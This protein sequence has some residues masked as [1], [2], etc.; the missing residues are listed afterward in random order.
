MGIYIGIDI[1]PNKINEQ[2]WKV[3]FEETLQLIQAYPFATLNM[4]SVNGFKRLVLERAKKQYIEGFEEEEGYWKINGDLKSKDT[5]ES[6]TMF[7]SLN[8]YSELKEERLKEDIL[9]YYLEDGKSGAREVFY[10]KTQGKDYHTYILAIAT[11]IE[12]RFPKCACVYGDI[13]KEQAQKAV[14]WVNSILE[15]P[16]DLPIRV[17]PAK[18]LERLEVIDIDEKRLEALYDLSI[19]VSEEVAVL[20]GKKFNI[21]TV[22]KYFAMELQG[23]D[24]VAQLGAKLIIIRYLNAGLPLEVLT[25]IC[26]FDSNGPRFNLFE[27]TKLICSTWVIVEP[28][29]R[30]NMNL[31]KR[32]T[33]NP[34]S[35]QAQIKNMFMDMEF[36]GRRT[37]RYIPKEE[38]IRI[39]TRKSY[40]G[41]QVDE[42]IESKYQEIVKMLEEEGRKLKEIEDESYAKTEQNVIHTLDKLLFWNDRYEINE[43]I[44]NTMETIKTEVEKS[45]ANR[46]N[47]M[48]IIKEAEEQN[49]LNKVLSQLIQD[50]HSLVLTREAWDW[51]EGEPY[52]VKKRM[53]VMLLMFMDSGELRKLY[54]ALFENKALFYKYIR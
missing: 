3:V 24:S 51:I 16:I 38:V 4:D 29:I 43:N 30:E 44:T 7:S 47:L 37:L 25:D 17:N 41:K 49:Q 10:N 20:V 45:I 42:I 48:Q 46:S 50:N 23:F 21:K 32:A 9:L 34:E 28:E 19:G 35:V 8:K 36:M 52:D 5:G 22:R 39:L 18:L 14:D 1:I 53:V 54:R 40:D 2:D 13:S 27:F 26:C 6:F 33:D 15:N 12:T 11:L 31:V